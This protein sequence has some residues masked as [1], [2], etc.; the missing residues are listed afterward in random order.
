MA[1]SDLYEGDTMKVVD[2]FWEIIANGRAADIQELIFLVDRQMG[3][4]ARW[5]LCG[6]MPP[7][8]LDYKV[9][10]VG[11]IPEVQRCFTIAEKRR[12]HEVWGNL[13]AVLSSQTQCA[14]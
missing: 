12:F 5:C 4:K 10:Y 3:E 11:P 8:V 9:M 1:T 2:L 6:M 14:G 7:G 13:W